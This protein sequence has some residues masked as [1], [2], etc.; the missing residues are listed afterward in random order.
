MTENTRT[1]AAGVTGRVVDRLAARGHTP[2]A[3][4]QPRFDGVRTS[5]WWSA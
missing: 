3:A 1:L 5:G 4:S 2:R